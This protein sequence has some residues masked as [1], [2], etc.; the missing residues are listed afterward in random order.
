M[1]FL[2]LKYILGYLRVLVYK[3]IYFNSLKLKGFKYYFGKLVDIE[4]GKNSYISMEDKNYLGNFCS[5]ICNDGGYLEIGYNNFFNISCKIVS[6]EHIK[7]GSNCMFGPNVT[8]FDH[9]HTYSDKNILICKQGF[10]KKTI[11]IG[12]NVWVGANVTITEGTT[13]GDNV[14]IGA[15]SV[16]INDLSSNGV[17]GGIPAKLLK[18][19]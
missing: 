12:S 7:I 18:T 8:I 13:I 9:N 16:V 6:L 4:I 15:N 5:I 14:V 19:I 10:T 2:K 3:I 17:Y 11:L 1:K